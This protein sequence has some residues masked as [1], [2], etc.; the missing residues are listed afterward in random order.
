[1][2]LARALR[3]MSEDASLYRNALGYTQTLKVQVKV[4]HYPR[5]YKIPAFLVGYRC[6]FKGNTKI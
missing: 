3:Q 6:I 4:I 1:M 5:I 2:R